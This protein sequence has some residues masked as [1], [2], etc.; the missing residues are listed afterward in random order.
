MNQTS[1][2]PFSLNGMITSQQSNHLGRALETALEHLLSLKHLDRLY[3]GMPRELDTD[4]FLDLAFE[5]LNIRI[6]VADEELAQVPRSGPLVVVANHPFGAIEGLI[7]ASLL[8]RIRPDVR[9]M[10]NFL[11]ERIPELKELFIPVDPFGG[12]Q[13]KRINHVP[14]KTAIDWL[15]QG[16]V[17]VV[18]PA[19]EVSHLSLN[20][21]QII[22][23]AWSKTIGRLIQLAEAPAQAI[24][25]HG[26][27]S[28]LFQLAGLIHPRLRTTLLPRELINKK[29]TPLSVRFSQTIAFDK[30]NRLGDS[31]AIIDYLRLR[32][33]MLRYATHSNPLPNLERSTTSTRAAPILTA[34]DPACLRADV[35]SL[36]P[37]Q[38]LVDGGEMRVYC[39]RAEQ[40]PAIM[41]EIGRLREITFRAAG[42]GTGRAL[43]VDYYDNYYLHL[44]IWHAQK[45]EVVGAYRLGQSDIIL[46]RFGIRGFYSHSLFN[47]SRQLIDTLGPSLELGRS[48]VRLEYQKSFAPLLLLWKGI[49]KYVVTHSQY[50][51][52]FGPV[53]ISSEYQTVSQQIMVE[54][55]KA[56]HTLK[57]LNSHVR[58]RRPFKKMKLTPGGTCPSQLKS[59]DDV[60]D[61]VAELEHD[62]K[63]VPILLKHYLKLGGKLLGFNVDPEFNNAL[64]GLIMVDL[65]ETAPR[66][67]A[68][69]MGQQGADTFLSHDHTE[70]EQQKA[71]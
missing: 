15:K 44:F 35:E 31:Q 19:G 6:E 45:N 4:S 2:S 36:E 59:I 33:Y 46:K 43:D 64:D 26:V 48:F 52:L 49:G 38:W 21:R 16:G 56:N 7:L 14:L 67:L 18:F 5:T 24:Y 20:R 70:Q 23:P 71:G 29:R 55:L 25:F 68:K 3:K 50:R 53:S 62:N 41:Q 61:V 58:P 13:A 66:L 51:K 28:K 8:R 60:A 27:N 37:E 30:L 47:Y 57:E 12:R 39:A 32:T 40:I 63:G 22:D 69:Y 9:I 65:V 54:F 42:E 1:R 11:L 10:A 17:L 34:A